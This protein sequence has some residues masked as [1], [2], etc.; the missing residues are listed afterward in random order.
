MKFF[1]I[2]LIFI[3]TSVSLE[4]IAQWTDDNTQVS[5]NGL[6]VTVA[7]FQYNGPPLNYA[8]SCFG[9]S[10]GQ[11]RATVNSGS[12]GPY[13]YEWSNGDE[14]ETVT[15]ITG[16][17][18][19]TFQVTV[20]DTRNDL[21][22][23]LYDEVTLTVSISSPPELRFKTSGFGVSQSNPLCSYT[24]DGSIS[25]K[26]TGGISGGYSY[27]WDDTPSTTNR[28]INGI[29]LGVYVV[30]VT[31]INS[32]TAQKSYT[33]DQPTEIIPNL[34]ITSE[35]CDGASGVITAV[36]SGGSGVY[37]S[38]LWDDGLAQTSN[39][40][41]GL[42]PGNYTV[43]VTDDDGCFRTESIALNSPTAITS[44]TSETQTICS[45]SSDGTSTITV[46]GGLAP[47]NLSWLGTGGSSGDPVGDEID[48][49]GENF[50]IS[51]LAAD[52]Y[53]VT[54]T[55]ASGCVETESF[56][57]TNPIAISQTNT[58][59]H[60]ACNGDGN[61]VI[62]F[63]VEN[64]S[65]PYDI[66]WTGPSNGSQNDAINISGGSYQITGLSGGDYDV[67]I[68]DNN[69][70]VLIA[71]A[72]TINEPAIL[73]QTNIKNE[74]SCNGGTDG[75]V[76]I[77]VTG[78]TAPYNVSWAGTAA[79]DPAGDEIV[80]DGGS[81][82]VTSL[83]VGS[84]TITIIDANNCNVSFVRNFLNPPALVANITSTTDISC[85]GLTDGAATVTVSGGNF[86]Y[87]YLWSNG[88]NTAGDVSGSNTASNFSQGAINVTVT[89]G[90][91]CSVIATE[92][93]NEPTALTAA[94]TK[95][96]DV[97]C[98]GAA[99]GSISVVG[100]GGTVATDY[101]YLWD[102]GAGQTTATATNLAPGNYTVTVTD[103]NGCTF[104]T[105]PAV[106]INQPTALTATATKV[107][108]V[109]CNGAADG[110]I[111]VSALG[112]TPNYTYL[113][114]DGAGQTT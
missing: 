104:T 35:G 45:T 16:Q 12:G 15:T 114:D 25:S 76:D 89:D 97:Q 2:F 41:T 86:P 46:S 96:Q 19:G 70:C 14:G 66:S 24:L 36:P 105:S 43:T 44:S 38:Y 6:D 29:G 52:N 109:Q 69:G 84:Y 1:K 39:P 74:I 3:L 83:G 99:D 9:G 71:N 75:S 61:G 79:A 108:D 67:T 60:I 31:D 106:S 27:S 72:N 91:S 11:I 113:W 42:V 7:T 101:T 100:A 93:I 73:S 80:I 82:S 55:D 102:D 58:K 87:S 22:G 47:Y 33:I 13:Y 62:D 34:E 59:T 57:I 40:A 78:G 63:T 90:N 37:S 50:L 88:E 8:V 51:P 23:G 112:G 85:N 110:S 5:G 17:S 107:Q 92:T 65:A 28:V 26:A 103:D 53:T 30:T 4:F 98:N 10:D 21:G 32:C 54:I 81:Y 56:T 95:V 48:N 94:A 68:T 49:A 18:A 111:S 20:Y 64:G 77:T